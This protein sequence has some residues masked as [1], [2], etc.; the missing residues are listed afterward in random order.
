MSSR[1]EGLPLV[2]IEAK[3]LGLPC[4]SFDCPN[5]PSEVIRRGTDG[6][7]IPLGDETK[8]AESILT[9]INDRSKIKEYGKAAY[10]DAKE[11]FSKENIIKEWVSL[12]KE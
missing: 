4:I 5:G 7:L 8:M 2:L 1:F 11:R 9:L 6:D 10:E 12:I 3:Q